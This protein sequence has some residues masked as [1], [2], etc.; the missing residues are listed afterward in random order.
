M[1]TVRPF[2]LARGEYGPVFVGL[3][4]REAVIAAHARERG[5][6]N[7]WECQQKYGPQTILTRLGHVTCGD[8]TAR[9]G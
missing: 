6:Y 3:T 9:R 8:W 7:T 1:A 2:N 4:P 5:D